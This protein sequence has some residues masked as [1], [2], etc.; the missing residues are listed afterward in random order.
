MSEGKVYAVGWTFG[1]NA[2]Y[3]IDNKSFTLEGNDPEAYALAVHNGDVY[4]AG[5]VMVHVTGRIRKNKLSGIPR[6]MVLPLRTM[7]TYLSVAIT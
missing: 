6:D 5:R 4:T 1:A 2:S 7:V 3:W